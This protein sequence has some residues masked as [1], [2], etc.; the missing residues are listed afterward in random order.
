MGTILSSDINAKATRQMDHISLCESSWPR[1]T[2]DS[3]FPFP[4]NH[5]HFQFSF[6]FNQRSVSRSSMA[7][8]YMFEGR[9][10]LG[11]SGPDALFPGRFSPARFDRAGDEKAASYLL[12][13]SAIAVD[14]NV[15]YRKVT[16]IG[17]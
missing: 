16:S 12:F 9:K 1:I 7:L 17:V 13:L 2:D 8:I 3:Y 4:V 5:F 10:I 14:V 6:N 15:K 11:K